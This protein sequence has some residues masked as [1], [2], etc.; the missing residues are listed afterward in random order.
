MGSLGQQ[1]DNNSHPTVL[2]AIALITGEKSASQLT[3]GPW[4]T[5]L[6]VL[7]ALE[8]ATKRRAEEGA[9]EDTVLTEDSIFTAILD[10]Q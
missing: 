3:G 8:A 2:L 6:Q 9:L 7:E 1:L 5:L 4:G 10:G